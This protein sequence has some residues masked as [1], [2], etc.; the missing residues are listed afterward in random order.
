MTAYCDI[1]SD[2]PSRV[3]RV[4]QRTIRPV[5]DD[6][7]D[8]SVTTMLMAASAGLAMPFE[9]L[10][11]SKDGE[12]CNWDDHPAFLGKDQAKYKKSLKACSEFLK[13]PISECQGL[14]DAVLLQCNELCDIQ[15][16]ARDGKGHAM[17]NL[18]KHDTRF[19]LGI[20]RN[21]LAHNNIVDVP[22]GID[23]IEKLAFFSKK[24][25]CGNCGRKDGWNVLLISV[26]DFEQFLNAW[27]AL[28]KEPGSFAGA[29]K[30]MASV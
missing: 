19:A 22:G 15:G 12:K 20:L 9:N 25:W 27:F 1:Y 17:L 7:E 6:T 24:D 14:K 30:A 8:L 18:Q 4:W 29:A 21:A 2:L 26:K 11:Y 3:Y 23:Q 16:S 10:R 28:L 5:A 13:R